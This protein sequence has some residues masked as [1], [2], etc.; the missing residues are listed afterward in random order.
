[1]QPIRYWPARPVCSLALILLAGSMARAADLSIHTSGS[2][3]ELALA[4]YMSSQPE[5]DPFANAG[6]VGVFI[7]A[8]LAELYKSAALLAV[9]GDGA[10][11]N[12]EL[13]VVQIAGDGT[14]VDEVIERYLAFRQQIDL[15]PLSSARIA[16][17]DYRYHFAGEVRTA[18]GTAMVYELTPRKNRPGLFQG[19]LWIDSNTGRE[20]ML[21][22]HITDAAATSRIEFVR[23]TNLMNGCAYAR[24]T[25]VAFVIPVLG[26]AEVS[27]TE[28]V[29]TP[30]LTP[31]RE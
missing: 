27:M 11:A 1:M 21:S 30:S 18:D 7:Q 29:L 4:R 24:V 31:Q 23:D 14:V 28:L 25:H 6:P 15:L 17:S 10:N 20:V 9:R 3:Q 12:R 19:Q 16:L 2:P 5:R 8:S 22:G 26:R 13:R